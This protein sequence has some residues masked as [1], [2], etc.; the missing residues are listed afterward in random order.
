MT[1]DKPK[2]E[3]PDKVGAKTIS[4]KE[5]SAALK[6]KKPGEIEPLSATDVNKTTFIIAGMI[7]RSRSSVDINDVSKALREKHEIFKTVKEIRDEIGKTKFLRLVRGGDAINIIPG[8]IWKEI[9][10]IYYLSLPLQKYYCRIVGS[11]LEEVQ[12]KAKFVP[13]TVASRISETDNIYELTLHTGWRREL[14][15]V[16]ELFRTFRGQDQFFGADELVEQL[17]NMTVEDTKAALK[18]DYMYEA[19]R[20]E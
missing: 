2:S 1:P 16:Q 13:V 9:R 10:N 14:R 11:T 12:K 8:Y 18:Y 17:R 3:S 20:E 19:E 15:C 7:Q 4:V 5:T 6:V